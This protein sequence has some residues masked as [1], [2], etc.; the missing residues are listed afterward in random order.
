MP[1]SEDFAASQYE[2]SFILTVMWTAGEH[3][4]DQITALCGP[5]KS[6]DRHRC[7]PSRLAFLPSG[8][9]QRP[10]I[11]STLHPASDAQ[12]LHVAPP[13]LKTGNK[14][15]SSSTSWATLDEKAMVS[16]KPRVSLQEEHSPASVSVKSLAQDQAEVDIE[17]ARDESDPTALEK[18][19]EKIVDVVQTK[20]VN[21]SGIPEITFPDGGLEAW[22]N[23]AGCT[24]ISLTAFGQVNAFGIFQTYYADHQLSSHSASDI[25]WIGSVQ[26]VLLY[27]SGLILGR[28]FDVHGAR[29][30][31]TCGCILSAFSTIMLSLSTKYYQIFLSQGVGLGLGIA[32]QFYPLVLRISVNYFPQLVIPA[33]WFRAKRAIALGIV[34]AGSSLGGIIFPIMLSKLFAKIGF[35]WSVRAMALVMFVLQAISIPFIKERMPA[36]KD[37]KI[38]DLGAYKD[39]RFLMHSLSGFFSAFGLYTPFWYIEL[40][41]LSRGS[42]A[43]LAFYSIAVM[44][45]AGVIG[46]IGSGYIADRFGRFNT[47]V[48]VA[49][50]Q[51]IAVFAIWTTA[52]SIAQT[53]VFA[54]IFGVSSASYSSIASS[55]VAQITADHSLIGT[56]TGM[57]MAAMAPGILAGPPIA[58]ALLALR[59]HDGPSV[60]DSGDFRYL[61]A[62]FFGG[63]MLVAGAGFA[64][65]ARIAC[66]RKRPVNQETVARIRA[67]IG[68]ASCSNA[69]AASTS[70]ATAVQPRVLTKAQKEWVRQGELEGE[71]QLKSDS[72]GPPRFDWRKRALSRV[73]PKEKTLKYVSR[74]QCENIP[75]KAQFKQHID[76]Y[77]DRFIPL[78]AAEQAI[79]EKLINDRLENW[80][81]E[82]LK[83]EGYCL[84]G[85][86][87]FAPKKT[88]LGRQV[89]RFKTLGKLPSHS[90]TYGAQVIVSRIDPLKENAYR[91]SVINIEPELIDVT[92]EENFSEIANGYWRLDLGASSAIYQRMRSAI[93]QL[94]CDSEALER[95]LENVP[96]NRELM[97]QGT[98]L[99]DVLLKSFAPISDND[100]HVSSPHHL[101]DPSEKHYLSRAQ[102]DHASRLGS[103]G[104]K[105]QLDGVF[106]EDCFIRSWAQ[107]YQ[108]PNPVVMEGDPELDGLNAS[109]VRA[110]ATMI[111]ER[112]SLVQGPPGTGKTKTIVETIKLLK[113]HFEVPHPLLVCTY[114][115]VAVD[116]L[117]ESLIANGLKPLRVG[118]EG[119][120]KVGLEDYMF[121]HQFENHVEKPAY[122][123]CKEAKEE[124]T[125]AIRDLEAKIKA[126]K[127]KERSTF[128]QRLEN[129]DKE[130]KS[131]EAKRASRAMQ[132]Y[133][134]RQTIVRD[135]I[136]KADV[137]CTTCV[138]SASYDLRV[139]DFPVVFLDEASM[140]TEPACLIPIV[141]GCKHLALI[142]DH[143][144][145]P[146]VVVSPKA[147]DG[148][149]AISLFERLT[150]EGNVPSIM[151]DTQYRMHPNISAFPSSEFYD[152]M[153]L[154]GTVNAG[155]VMP[156]LM[157]LSSSHLVANPETGHRPSVIFIDHEGPEATKSK[158]RVNWT[159]GYIICSIVED[160]LRQNKD[161]L[162]ENIGI[163]APYK[164]Q[165]GV[166]TRLLMKDMQKHFIESLGQDRAVEIAN[167]EIKTVDGFEGREK[168]AIVFSTVRN[169]PSGHI[170]FLADRRRLNVGLTR[171]KRALFVVGSM[172]T[173]EKGKFGWSDSMN[174]VDDALGQ[175]MQKVSKGAVAWRNYAQYLTEQNLVL[176][177]RGILFKSVLGLLPFPG[178]CS[179]DPERASL[180]VALKDAHRRHPLLAVYH[181]GEEAPTPRST[182]ETESLTFMIAM[183]CHDSSTHAYKAEQGCS[184]Q[185]SLVSDPIQ[186]TQLLNDQLRALGLYAA[187]TLGDGN[188]LFRALSDQYYGSPSQH[189]KLRDEVCSWMEVHKQRYA[190]F[191]DDERGL[192]VH[193]RCTYG[194]HL[195]LTAFAHLKRRDVKVI[196]PGLVYIIEWTSGADLSPTESE[197]PVDEQVPATP[198]ASVN[199]RD[200]RRVR[201]DK[202]KDVKAKRTADNDGEGNSSLGAVFVAYHDWE[203][204]S[205]V[206]N[207]TGPHS[208][209]PY[210]VEKPAGSHPVLGK[211]KGKSSVPQSSQSSVESSLLEDDIEE[212]DEGLSSPTGIPLP[213]SRSSSLSPSSEASTSASSSLS[214]PPVPGYNCA[215][216]NNRRVPATRLSLRSN[217]SPKRAY[218]GTEEAAQDSQGEAKRSRSNIGQR[219]TNSAEGESKID[220]DIDPDADTPSLLSSADSSSTL[221][222]PAAT[223]PPSMVVVPPSPLIPAKPL[224]RRQRKVLGLPKP[225]SAIGIHTS[226]SVKPRQVSLGKI[227][228]PGGRFKKPASV[229]VKTKEEG[230]NKEWSKNGTGRVDVRGFKELKI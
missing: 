97:L 131:L 31:L 118:F 1:I 18:A 165:I 41:M 208:G 42:S 174:G 135:I 142:G 115:N 43:N 23:V 38:F 209:F 113:G 178:S 24:L 108:K 12:P 134:V 187:P 54:V 201:R 102:L 77:A 99:V 100:V 36:S 87:S 15:S 171:A 180:C 168:D 217:R 8:I 75:K 37:K 110:M 111:G 121:Q 83:K 107:R 122:T 39:V 57:F 80:G 152:L 167:I 51:A 127:K 96:G 116:N 19:A 146:P 47:V 13:P 68:G 202:R 106:S 197:A 124:V 182:S 119:K 220:T 4:S 191:V 132:E 200:A 26:I 104:G 166:L 52:M 91:G 2:R 214:V 210:V 181:D 139:V 105:P 154:D 133:R 128:S 56:R 229:P 223:P 10:L 219:H 170:G 17:T 20:D 40:F 103:N 192:D 92:F 224:T 193:L 66:Q 145:L 73:I 153:L 218:D 78:I 34:V 221:S 60:S 196:Q 140:S 95:D 72:V 48:P 79:E 230:A 172:S 67:F 159:E 158:S 228:V 16:S 3:A 199:D 137:I 93:K 62:Q 32:L 125:K 61:W 58:G 183:W 94:H 179:W 44:N 203:H 175:E 55:C 173:L 89:A 147:R 45:A 190:P 204:F 177:L 71:L 148:G 76:A 11:S 216:D 198:E 6:E 136:M 49:V 227:I 184:S 213:L 85:L 109:Q 46:R 5:W 64:F 86:H 215:P 123:K 35:A 169:N 30:L 194:G 33:H 82:R 14:G 150:E 195:E 206:R 101:Q 163:I 114:T 156:T 65:A 63:A 74:R 129:M 28:V 9:P 53:L 211:V 70:A 88:S 162:G 151:L 205:S 112:I 138:R 189:L 222:S 29:G 185:Y 207:L 117:L 144:Q 21:F 84:T 149:L 164:S 81:L 22:S 176:R 188:C 161:L 90:F 141:K 225:R 98:Q 7:V 143:K 69:R 120:E 130:L 160:L 226:T 27:I 50:I 126:L 157:P 155:Q 25:S 186:N 59:S 212:A